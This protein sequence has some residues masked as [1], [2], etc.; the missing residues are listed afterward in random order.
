[1]RQYLEIKENLG[2]AIVFFRMGDFYEMFFEDAVTAS[3]V[4]GIALTSRDRAK[5]IPMCGFPYH[6]STGYIK[7]LILE[8]HKVAVCEQ[9]EEAD[10]QKGPLRR[11]VVRVI[12]PGTALE[13]ELLEPGSNN[14][15]AA[16]NSIGGLYGLSYMDLSTGEFMVTEFDDLGELNDELI[17]L[18]PLE[19]IVSEEVK[20]DI[21]GPGHLIRKVTVLGQSQF[22][23]ALNIERLTAHFQTSGL[24]GFGCSG[25]KAGAGAAGALLDYIKDTQR[26]ELP[27]IRKLTPYERGDYM[28]LDWST[29]RNLELTENNRDGGT[30]GT[31]LAILDMTSTAMGAR[32]LKKWMSRPLKESASIKKRLNAVDELFLESS[33]REELS[34]LLKGV[35]DLQRLSARVSMGSASPR[36]LVALKNS[37]SEI[38]TIKKSLSS[39][40]SELLHE[41]GDGLDEVQEAVNFIEETIVERPPQSIK[42]GGVIK[43]GF[44][45]ELDGYREAGAGGKDWI[46][47]LER[48]EREKT[49]IHTLKVGYNRVFGYYIEVTRA[50]LANV[51]EGYVRKQTLVNAERFI[52]EDLK[53]WEE[54]ILRAEGRAGELEIILYREVIERLRPLTG[55]VEATAMLVA[56]LDVLISFSLVAVKYNYTKPLLT[57]N[58]LIRIDDGRHPVVEA[59][60]S[61]DFVGNDLSVDSAG[62]S[63][64]ILTGPNMAGKSTYLRQNALIVYMA[65]IGSFVSAHE[66]HIGIV[67]RIFTR[68]GASDDLRRGQSTFMVEMNETANILNNATS[69]SLIILDE[70]GR[71]TSTFDGLSIAWAVVEYLHDHF[72]DPPKTLFATHYHELTEL[73]LTKDGV[74]NYNMAVKEWE[75][76]IIFLR[77]VLPG[78]AGSSYGIHVASLAGLPDEVLM[79]ARQILKNLEGSELTERG[80]PRLAKS[81]GKWGEGAVTGRAEKG[82]DGDEGEGGAGRPPQLEAGANLLG[83]RDSLREEIR[84]LKLDSTTPMEALNLLHKL[85]EMINDS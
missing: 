33:A 65:Q 20:D 21:M 39:R 44:N 51:P 6:A 53:L 49:G 61:G 67:D 58:S 71:G 11:E 80:L 81:R 76:S 34:T 19:A 2:D 79:R 12:T 30:R 72:T 13:D 25:L 41:I 1:M 40:T 69:K 85:K 7:K 43:A 38:A 73:S 70:I 47:A 36:D 59:A 54:R 18:R 8:G 55:R 75:G 64:I 23:T 56:K 62:E 26:S 17:S 52:T 32:L 37:L 78:Q 15:I 60:I 57:E 22:G 82:G 50:N 5:E 42:D 3:K 24:E 31:L 4:L 14:F 66:A 63:I 29:A 27:H 74:K 28:L 83:P 84:G 35:Y 68:V 46:A 48:Q 77:K 16:V 9:V 45:D 10:P